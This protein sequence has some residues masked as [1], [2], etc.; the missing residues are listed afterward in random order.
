MAFGWAE[1]PTGNAAW[2]PKGESPDD[3]HHLLQFSGNDQWRIEGEGGWMHFSMPTE[4][5]K[6]GDFSRAIPTHDWL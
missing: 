3:Y 1:F 4:A 5:L 2:F 6:A